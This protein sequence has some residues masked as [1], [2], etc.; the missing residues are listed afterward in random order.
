M[1]QLTRQQTDCAL[2]TLVCALDLRFWWR[3]SAEMDFDGCL[4]QI[5]PECEGLP[6]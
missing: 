6:V 1:S 4:P 2:E 5:L 3:F